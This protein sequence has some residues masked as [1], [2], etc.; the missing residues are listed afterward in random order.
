MDKTKTSITI[1][2]KDSSILRVKMLTPL[3]PNTTSHFLSIFVPQRVYKH[4]EQ[5]V[6]FLTNNIY[7]S[8]ETFRLGESTEFSLADDIYIFLGD[9]LKGSVSSLWK[10][11][12]KEREQY[13]NT[14]GVFHVET[15]WKRFQCGIH[16]VFL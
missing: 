5:S 9:Q 1:L 11:M 14:P 3:P 15:M 7:F 4:W 10:E 8:L 16:M 12:V 2:Q 6:H 13:T